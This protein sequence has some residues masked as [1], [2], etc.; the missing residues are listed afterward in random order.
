MAKDWEP[1]LYSRFERE[2]T[3][4][5]RDLLAQCEL[6]DPASG[7]RLRIVDLGCGPGNSTA[8]LR[9]RFPD[10]DILG[11]DTSPA[12]LDAARRRLPDCRFEGGDIGALGDLGR[13]D[14][15]F[16]NA[17]LQ[18]VPDHPRLLPALFALVAP[19]GL[20]AAQVP[21]NLADPSQTEMRRIAADPEFAPW[22]TD[23][24]EA[25]TDIA[26][27]E[28][29]YDMLAGAGAVADVWTTVYNHPLPDAAAITQWF[30]S[31]GLRPFL[32]PLPDEA[33]ARFEARYTQAVDAAYPPRAD[34]SRLLAFPRL[35]WTARRLG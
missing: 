35:F 16:T 33:R 26:P 1:A 7:G 3:R 5:A 12:M 31:T 32:D 6:G 27:R 2:R 14:L 17:A 30:R 9:E 8:L 21:D 11:I 24:D 19:G 28:A 10:A 20:F 23:I 15:V 22:L 29:I 25:R 34:G 18:W 4:P 13:F